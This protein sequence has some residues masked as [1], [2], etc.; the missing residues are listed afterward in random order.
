M[1]ALRGGDQ[2]A[3]RRVFEEEMPALF[4]YAYSRLGTHEDAEE[5]TN[6]VFVEAWRSIGRYRDDGLPLRAWLFGI[7][8]NLAGAHRRRFMAR[9]A[10]ISAHALDLPD[11]STVDRAAYLDLVTAL[12]SIEALQAEVVALRYIHNLSLEETAGVLKTTV[13]AVK[14]R[15]KRALIAPRERLEA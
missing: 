13:D 2:D 3:W 10:Q 4:R 11:G 15:Q 14:G 6:Q 5:V 9:N 1:N 7:A 8:R 12:Q